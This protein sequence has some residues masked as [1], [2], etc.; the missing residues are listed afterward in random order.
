MNDMITATR[1]GGYVHIGILTV[2]ALLVGMGVPVAAESADK[3][4]VGQLAEQIL[5]KTG[6]RGGLIIHLGCGDGR[7][8][9]ALRTKACYLVHG[10]DDDP[11]NVEKARQTL[12]DLGVYGDVSVDRF[13]GKQL[14]YVDNLVNLVVASG[15]CQVASEEIAR[16]LAPN[17][18]ALVPA[19]SDQ[20]SAI[21]REEIRIGSRVWRRLVKPWPKEIDEWTHYLY[22]ESGNAVSQDMVVGPPRHFQWTGSPR[23]ARHHD[24]RASV[25]AMVSAGGR[26][27]YIFD[28]GST[29]SIM[30]PPKTVLIAR[31]AFNGTIL[32]KRDIPTW[33]THLWPFKSGPTQ[34]QRRLVAI[35]DT[36][37]VTLGLDA[38]LVAL[39][40]ATGETVRTY[41][42]TFA[43]EEVIASQGV[44]FALVNE[45]PQN[46]DDFKPEDVGIGAE[47][48]RVMRDWPW[49]E[50]PRY[51]VALDAE[52]GRQM[53]NARTPVVPLTLAVDA[54]RIYFHD[55]D[56]VVALDRKTGAPLWSS[57]PVERQAKVPTNITP[58]LVVYEDV[59]LFYGATRKLTGVSAK[60]GKVL[61]TEPHP[62]SGHYCPEDVLVAG[63]LVWG[64]EIAGGRDSGVFIGRDPRT[65]EIKSQ[66]PP[67]IDI[68]FMHQRCYRSKAT[69]RFLIPG[70]TGTEYIDFRNKHWVTNHWVRSGCIYG[71]MPCN[72]LTYTTPHDCACYMQAKLYGF[73]ALAAGRESK[74]P[75]ENRLERGP[76]YDNAGSSLPVSG[77]VSLDG[78]PAA[79][80]T[81]ELQPKAGG[82]P[83]R[84]VTD[85]N[86]RY[87]LRGE[88]GRNGA[89]PGEYTVTIIKSDEADEWPTYRNDLARSGFT[90]ASVSADL[91]TKWKAKVG[92]RLSSVVVADGKLFVASVDTHTV[93]AL[94]AD[95][96]EA[97]WSFTAGGR[98]DSPP[99]IWNGRV[100]FGSADGF[101]YCLQASDGE[102]AWRFRAGPEDRRMTSFEQVE[103]VW[104]VSGSVLVQDGVVYCVAGRS[105]FLDGGLRYLR[106]DA[107]SGKL[108]SEVIF[109]EN[110]PETG[111]NLQ[112][113]V[114]VRNMPV[115]LPDVLSSDGKFLYMRSQQ[116][117]PE[118]KRASLVQIKGSDLDRGADQQGPATHLFSPTGFLDD[119]WWHRSYWVY[120]QRFSEGAG[121]WPQAGKFAPAGR[122]MAVDD[123]NVYGFGRKPVYY[124]WRTPLEYH[125]FCAAKK[126]ETVREPASPAPKA[127]PSSNA[128]PKAKARRTAK[129]RVQHPRYEWSRNIPFFVR[130]MVLADKT[131]FIAGPPDVVDEEEAFRRVGDPEMDAKLA[132]QDAVLNGAKGTLLWAVSAETGDKLAEYKFDCLPVFDSLIATKGHLYVSTTDGEVVCFAGND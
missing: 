56:K 71:I 99:T 116:F 4:D 91:A 5:E 24:R 77:T 72:G 55:G 32:W 50:K 70:W 115:G 106:I 58:T 10:L 102:L 13:C 129:P 66:F 41:G 26:I 127:K 18:V 114:E 78:K 64:G 34:L 7:L 57:D 86:G 62:R 119:T 2:V 118:G 17:G 8:T 6:V 53:W 49:N 68:Y 125:L 36:V 3:S 122:I 31:D 95:S 63:G 42:D 90:T 126:P 9:A 61:W 97:V 30:L 113:H 44:L 52:T 74:S 27:F 84:G 105:M 117:D 75:P 103:S 108:I 38:S 124:R 121:G 96:G 107:D 123:S 88:V 69:D 82:S 59:V 21:S 46:Y 132:E 76:A 73:C 20:R 43:T 98:V 60:T 39:D 94:T 11:E 37:Y 51:I 22:D 28:E 131:L 65:G 87:E 100:L 48:D 93:H 1:N 109:D 112:T 23:W 85:S 47:R 101:V 89:K 80:L 45:K 83:L 35:G 33:H 67:D 54:D 104:P 130:A 110:D 81:V 79:G 14:P 16:V 120:G 12:L 19:V 40:A 29:A 25:S 128:R 15:E 92:G 111:E